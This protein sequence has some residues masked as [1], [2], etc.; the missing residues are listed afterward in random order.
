MYKEKIIKS[1]LYET[2]LC[3]IVT[4][5]ADEV[6]KRYDLDADDPLFANTHRAGIKI[7]GDKRKAMCV[8][9][10]FGPKFK[11][12]DRKLTPGLIAHESLHAANFILDY[13]G[14]KADYDNDE[15]QAYL[16]EWIVNQSTEFLKPYMKDK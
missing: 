13:V 2:R 14:V 4:D 3:L 7:K 6:N 9:L 10:I 8:Y 5:N 1:P 11:F 12:G 16:L 15:P